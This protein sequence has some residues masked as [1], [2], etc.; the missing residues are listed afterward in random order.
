MTMDKES[1][2]KFIQEQGLV[3]VTKKL[4]IAN[5]FI[6]EGDLYYGLPTLS[7]YSWI[8][9]VHVNMILVVNKIF[10]TSFGI[11]TF[12]PRDISEY[13][14]IK[15]HIKYLIERSIILLKEE[16]ERM[17]KDKMDKLNNDFEI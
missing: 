17:I 6:S 3:D 2:I 5:T 7:P 4:P 13:F 10:R 12:D 16:K 9:R 14:D 1:F 11:N 15:A 8:V